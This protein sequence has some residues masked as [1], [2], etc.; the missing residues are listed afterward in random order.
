LKK[1][2]LGLLGLILIGALI[3]YLFIKPY[4]YLVSFTAD[5]TP[6]TINQSIKVWKKTLENSQILRQKGLGDLEQQIR[7]NDSTHLYHWE[8]TSIEEA[9]SKV[10]VY[11]KD[12]DH[13]LL[14]KI[15]IPFSNTDFEKRSKKTLIGFKAFLTDHIEKTRVQLAGEDEVKATFCAYVALKGLQSEKALGMMRTYP[16][17]STILVDNGIELN[18]LPFIEVTKWDMQTDSIH[19]N[20][21][22]PILK[23]ATFPK[24]PDLK[25]K[26]I[27]RK[28][29]LKAIYHGHYNTSDRAWYTL[30]EHAKRNNVEVTGLPV[31]YFYNNP[32]VGANEEEWRAEVYMPLK[33]Q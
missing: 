1:K 8:I 25:Y 29:A 9:R 11:I 7:F 3:W 2:I 22:F 5:T 6:G 12:N 27:Y 24:H 4:D 17:L 10:K 19:Y 26:Q 32:N 23:S 16:L 15:T 31:E 14:N 18:G 30:L 33:D 20:F 28:K 21:C 13:S